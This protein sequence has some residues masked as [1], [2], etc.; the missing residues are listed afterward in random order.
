LPAEISS[1][2]RQTKRAT[3]APE[4]EKVI[5]T[6]TLQHLDATSVLIGENVRDDAA[7]DAQ[8]IANVREHG[9][10]NPS[11]RDEDQVA[12]RLDQI[13]TLDASS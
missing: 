11:Q 6:G 1:A 10:C 12:A 2:K 8:F 13:T 5:M 9:V 7:L 4:P 3:H